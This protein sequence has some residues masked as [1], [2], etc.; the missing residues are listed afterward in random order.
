MILFAQFYCDST[1]LGC[2]WG[3]IG[4]DR[5]AIGSDRDLNGLPRFGIEGRIAPIPPANQG[6]LTCE[7]RPS[8]FTSGAVE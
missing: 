8:A 4:S 3:A 2:D 1:K 6:H 5:G 7:E